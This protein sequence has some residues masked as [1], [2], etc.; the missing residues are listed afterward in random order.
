MIEINSPWIFR[1]FS[2]YNRGFRITIKGVEILNYNKTIGWEDNLEIR[3]ESGLLWKIIIEGGPWKNPEILARIWYWKAPKI[4]HKILELQIIGLEN[5][6]N[7][8]K[9]EIISDQI[10]FLTWFGDIFITKKLSN[11]WINTALALK[12]IFPFKTKLKIDPVITPFIHKLEDLA[13]KSEKIINEANDAFLLLEMAHLSHIGLYKEF[14]LDH[15]KENIIKEGEEFVFLGAASGK[16]PEIVQKINKIIFDLGLKPSEIMVICYD[17]NTAEQISDAIQCNNNI[18]EIIVKY[19]E[20]T[21]KTE[22]YEQFYLKHFISN[23]QTSKISNGE[24][25]DKNN[26][27]ISY[28]ISNEINEDILPTIE[29]SFGDKFNHSEYGKGTIQIIEPL[30]FWVRFHEVKVTKKIDRRYC[31]WD[32]SHSYLYNVGKKLNV[33][34]V[35]PVSKEIDHPTERFATCYACG[36]H[37]GTEFNYCLIC[38]GRGWLEK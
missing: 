8:Y 7:K 32:E 1:L 10:A 13:F 14:T 11:P 33:Q 4:I 31:R 30:F 28:I 9:K 12:A 24:T 16:I 5:L 27:K 29:A 38:Y 23:K 35:V 15:L 25:T 21:E 18:N 2:D 36:G 22:K 17:N 19:F 3:I 34:K 37:G 20:K 26:E 6:F